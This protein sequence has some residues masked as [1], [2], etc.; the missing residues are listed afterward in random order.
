MILLVHGSRDFPK[1]YYLNSL[2]HVPNLSFE[3]LVGH[4]KPV[5]VWAMGVITYFLL[6]GKSS[7]FPPG[8]F[9]FYFCTITIIQLSITFSRYKITGYTPFDRDTQREEMEAICRGDYKFE[10]GKRSL[11]SDYPQSYLTIIYR[12]ILG[13]CFTNWP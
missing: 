12:G 13:G 9:P 3:T 10:P 6:C 5:D 8:T 11:P 2:W 4:G 7:Y 1:R